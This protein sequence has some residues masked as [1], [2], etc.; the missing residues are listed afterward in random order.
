MAVRDPL[1]PA[2]GTVT[3]WPVLSAGV[4]PAAGAANT[5][6]AQSDLAVTADIVAAGYAGDVYLESCTIRTPSAGDTGK[7]QL[8]YQV[9]AGAVVQLCEVDFEC[10]TDAGWT[11][12]ASILG[13]GG[14]IPTG[15]DIVCRYKTTGGAVTLTVSVGITELI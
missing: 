3:T 14:A 10:A 15:A 2:Y 6:G 4:A 8:G 5:Y 1:Y 13:A 11:Q 7:I 12:R 9:G